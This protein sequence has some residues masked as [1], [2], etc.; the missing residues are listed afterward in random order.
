MLCFEEFCSTLHYYQSEVSTTHKTT[1][2]TLK[3][4]NDV[5]NTQFLFVTQELAGQKTFLA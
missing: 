1:L 4:S 2:S 3:N 5:K